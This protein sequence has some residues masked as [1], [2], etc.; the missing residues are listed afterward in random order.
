MRISILGGGA[1]G[2]ALTTV[3]TNN[4]HDVT[5]WHRSQDTVRRIE[6]CR[7]NPKLPGIHLD[8]CITVTSDLEKAV[9][10]AEAVV[11]ATPSYGVSETARKI[12][13]LL[14]K[15][16]LVICASKGIEKDTSRLFSDI[17]RE[18]L[19]GNVKIASIS[20]PMHAEEV[21]RRMPTAC[22]AASAD[23]QIAALVQDI[24]MNDYLRVYTSTDVIGVELGAA[25]KNV[26]ALCAGVSDGLGFGD[27][28]IA[29]LMTRGL[30]EIARLCSCLGGKKATLA[31]LA[32]LGD[33]I[34]TCTSRHSRNRRAGVFIGQGCDVMEA[35][36]KVGA[37]VEGYYAAKAAFE[38]AQKTGIEMPIITEAY[39]VLY[40]GKCP[41][42]AMRELMGRN[43]RR[44]SAEEDWVTQ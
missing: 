17:L 41:R 35:M 19:G 43:K 18:T 14:P 3:L 22:V 2:T 32:G 16:T 25:L 28:T 7:E 5:L 37:A 11:L 12:A 21:A 40:E 27:N 8:K 9:K 24:F 39:R 6:A 36:E 10:S 42:V 20:G 38:L 29:M 4:G 13:G 34:V 44:E 31:G 1:W 15:G 23:I 30:A 26:I 33:L